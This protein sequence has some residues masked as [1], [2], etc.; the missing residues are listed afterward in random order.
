MRLLLALLLSSSCLQAAVPLSPSTWQTTTATLTTNTYVMRGNDCVV[1]IPNATSSVSGRTNNLPSAA[2]AR[3]RMV[4]IAD[5]GRT[6]FGTNVWIVARGADTIEAGP[7]R[8]N[9]IADGGMVGLI[10]NS[11]GT[12]WDMIFSYPPAALSRN[13]ITQGFV[14]VETTNT[15]G[16]EIYFYPISKQGRPFQHI[17]FSFTN[18]GTSNPD[19]VIRT[20]STNF[21]MWD[22][23]LFGDNYGLLI[24][25]GS[26]PG[27]SDT[28]GWSYSDLYTTTKSDLN[29]ATATA[30]QCA[31]RIN[32]LIKALSRIGV[33]EGHGLLRP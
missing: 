2:A 6:A 16:H 3:G 1:Y 4:I 9:I 28:K 24:A 17:E 23:D 13:P 10:A 25:H 8:T 31:E 21:W 5:G 29:P 30:A 19:F 11:T 22:V 26:H 15:L 7:T 33:N 14:A 32:A 18:S 27:A 12:G 20:A